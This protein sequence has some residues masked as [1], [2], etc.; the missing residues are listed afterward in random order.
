MNFVKSRKDVAKNA[1]E[2]VKLAKEAKPIKSAVKKA[3]DVAEPEKKWDEY[4]DDFIKTSEKLGEVAGK[5][6]AVYEDAKSAFSAV[7]KACAD[8]H[9]VF[10]V[11]ENF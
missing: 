4:M 8:C 1:K 11:E 5:T 10:R 6:N 7:K 3:K 9:K 2:L